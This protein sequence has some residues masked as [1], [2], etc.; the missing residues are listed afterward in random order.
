MQY[1]DFG[2]VFDVWFE[3][4]DLTCRQSANLGFHAVSVNFGSRPSS[5]ISLKSLK[6]MRKARHLYAS[7]CIVLYPTASYCIMLYPTASYFTLLYS[8]S[9]FCILLRSTVFYCILLYLTVSKIYLTLSYCILMYPTLSYC[10]LLQANASH[11]IIQCSKLLNP[12]IW[13]RS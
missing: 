7:H 13:I 11:S 5:E 1:L 9:S 12:D 6:G 10:I 2:V 8:T 4:R 3:N